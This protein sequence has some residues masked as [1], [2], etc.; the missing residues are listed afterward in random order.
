MEIRSEVHT[1]DIDFGHDE[2]LGVHVIETDDAVVQ[3]GTGTENISE[4]IVEIATENE[5]EIA[6]VEHGDTD[7]YGGVP[8]L[9]E[10]AAHITVA[11]P[12]GDVELLEEDGIDVDQPLEAGTTYWGIRTV[13]APGH[14]PDN[15]AYLYEDILIAGDTVVNANSPFAAARDWEGQF[16]ICKPDYNYDHDETVES[17]SRLLDFEFDPVLVTHGENV[18][19]GGYEEIQKL[20]ADLQQ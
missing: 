3:F 14:T 5:V 18:L 12:E 9:R 1:Y 4:D 17:V 15:M 7:H 19:E 20:A 13:P 8:A 2:P 16:G 11:C 10:S 6:V